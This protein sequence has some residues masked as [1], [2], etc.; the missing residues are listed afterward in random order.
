MI[1]EF[2]RLRLCLQCNRLK[3]VIEDYDYNRPRPWDLCL[4]PPLNQ[5]K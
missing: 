1:T 2:L 3:I 4:I 5:N